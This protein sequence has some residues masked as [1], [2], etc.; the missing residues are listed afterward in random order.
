MVHEIPPMF[1]SFFF[2]YF[3]FLIFIDTLG[4]WYT[5]SHPLKMLL[6]LMGHGSGMSPPLK[7]IFDTHGAAHPLKRN[8]DTHGA[9]YTKSHPC[10]LLF[11]SFF[12]FLIFIDTH[13]A[14]YTIS[15][16][17]KMLLILMGHGSGMSPPLKIIF[18]T[19]EA[20]HPLKR[21]VDTHGAWYTKSH[22]CFLLFFSF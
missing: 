13:G 15:H 11:F 9:W 18:D 2:I 16:P 19:H 21:N 1:S 7:I 6:I 17:L 3:Y 22:P 10:F 4:A 5:I 20:A 8:V 14:W 12:F